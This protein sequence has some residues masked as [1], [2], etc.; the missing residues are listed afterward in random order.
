MPMAQSRPPVPGPSD[1]PA[2]VCCRVHDLQAGD[3]ASPSPHRARRADSIDEAF[4]DVTTLDMSGD[5]LAAQLQT[6]IRD[7]LALSCSLGVATNKLVAKV[8]TDVGKSFVRLLAK[9]LR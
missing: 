4:L 5:V 1:R 9:R 8:T 2:A 7:D 6:T 3:A